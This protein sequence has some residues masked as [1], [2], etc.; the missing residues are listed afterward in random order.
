[1]FKKITAVPGFT[2]GSFIKTSDGSAVITGTPT[3]TRLVDGTAGSCD[4]AASYD[5]TFAAWKIDLTAGDMN[6]AV[7]G[8]KFALMDCQPHTFNIK[9]VSGVPDASGYYPADVKVVKTADADT[10]LSGTAGADA[11]FDR[12]NGV[13]AG[14]TFRQVMR[15]IASVLLGRVT[16]A[17][18]GTETF[19]SVSGAID[20]VVF[21]DDGS[22][23]RISAT[24]TAT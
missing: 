4:N 16:G 15:L 22:G 20:R 8:L 3:C 19:E 13:E 9:T 17:Q 6:G 5:A 21:E 1:M 2:I 24:Y 18:T 11:H 23:N 10:W 12:P 7:I 14:F